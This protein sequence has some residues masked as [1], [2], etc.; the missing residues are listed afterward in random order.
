MPQEGRS[1]QGTVRNVSI[2]GMLLEVD[3]GFTPAQDA[4]FT[5]EVVDSKVPSFIPKDAK[6]VWFSHLVSDRRRKFCGLKFVDPT[7]PTFSRLQ[8]HVD[9][10]LD[11]VLQATNLNIINHYLY[12]SN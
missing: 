5:I 3:D 7:G 2:S 1:G 10:R 8:E 9:G 11:N 6:M 4:L 12:Q